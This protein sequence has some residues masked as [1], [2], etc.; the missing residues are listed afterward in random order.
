MMILMMVS[1]NTFEQNSQQIAVEF[2]N[3][4]IYSLPIKTGR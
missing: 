1:N 3:Q 4:K 2:R